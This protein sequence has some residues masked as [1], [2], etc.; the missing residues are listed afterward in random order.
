MKIT[1]SKAQWELIGK[2]TGWM[3]KEAI[4]K[5]VYNEPTYNE[6]KNEDDSINVSLNCPH[7]GKPITKTSPEFGMDCEDD[8][9][10]KTYQKLLKTNPKVKLMDDFINSI[11]PKEF[12]GEGK[13]GSKEEADEKMFNFINQLSQ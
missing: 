7:C 3:K 2:N 8:C 11:Q 6:T 10:K 1:L 12:G 5:P 4:D 9:G 13:D